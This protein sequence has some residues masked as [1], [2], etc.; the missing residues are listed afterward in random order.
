MGR[1]NHKF[2]IHAHGM[3]RNQLDHPSA[4]L[5]AVRS[6]GNNTKWSEFVHREAKVWQETVLG[7]LLRNQNRPIMVTKYEDL[8]VDVERE[9]NR[10]L[11]FLQV[12]YS[13]EQ[14]RKV[15]K[16]GYS[17]YHRQG[18]AQ[19]EHYT[20]SQKDYVRGVIRSTADAIGDSGLVDISDYAS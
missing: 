8:L 5:H 4:F 20:Q 18:G 19:F 7:W 16:E 9:L 3:F 2:P 15:V 13:R 10:I 12:P 1:T 11:V 17:Q 14:L 6:A